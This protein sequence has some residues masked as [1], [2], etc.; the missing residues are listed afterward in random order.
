[1][2][3]GEATANNPEAHIILAF[4]PAS[5]GGYE[6]RVL[7]DRFQGLPRDHQGFLLGGRAVVREGE[8]WPWYRGPGRMGEA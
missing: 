8:T 1:M 5:G 2:T 7:K 6:I 4:Y 3:E